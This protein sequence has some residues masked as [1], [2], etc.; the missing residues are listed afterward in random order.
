[1]GWE[2]RHD[3]KSLVKEMV[4]CDLAAETIPAP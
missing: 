1:L 4:A 2:K 3:F